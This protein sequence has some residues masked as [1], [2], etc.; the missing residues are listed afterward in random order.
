MRA[1]AITTSS[2]PQQPVTGGL[3]RQ[4]A[5]PRSDQR[6]AHINFARH[7]FDLATPDVCV[8]FITA[9]SE[10]V[11]Q[12]RPRRP[13]SL[14]T[15]PVADYTDPPIYVAAEILEQS[16]SAFVERIFVGRCDGIRRILR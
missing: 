10:S 11:S 7:E 12:R 15:E 9:C 2:L 8:T 16:R 6:R 5:M 14:V 3:Y 4:R 1:G 13:R